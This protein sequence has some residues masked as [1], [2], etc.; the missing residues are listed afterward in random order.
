MPNHSNFV[1]LLRDRAQEMPEQTLYSFLPDGETVGSSLT[2]GELDQRARAIAATLQQLGVQGERA[3]LIYPWGASLEFIAAF[4]GCLYAGVVAVTTY[5][6]RPNQSLGGFQ[7]RLTSSQA[8]LVLTTSDQLNKLDNQQL[9]DLPLLLSTQKL[10]TDTIPTKES[11]SWIESTFSPDTLAF[12]QYTSGSTG[13]PKGVMVTHGNLIHNSAAIHASFQTSPQD[14]SLI[15]LPLFHDMGLIGGVLQPLYAGFRVTLMS[16]VTFLQNPLLWL[17][18]ISRYR[19]TITGAPNFAYDQCA[20]K[21]P[22]SVLPS[23]DLSS[24][25]VAFSGAEPVRAE[26][27][28]LFASK[29]APCGFRKEA[30]Y[31]CYGMAEAT[32]LVSGGLRTEIPQVQYVEGAALEENRVVPAVPGAQGTRS[33]VSCGRTWEGQKVVIVHPETRIPVNTG[34]VGEIWVSGEGL[35]KGYWQQPEETEK[36]FHAYLAADAH[37]LPNGPYLR[38]GDLGFLLDEDLFITGRLKNT[39]VIWGRN[40]YPQNIEHTAENSHPALRPSCS[41]AFAVEIDGEERLVVALEVER[42]HLRQLDA[43]AVVEC[44][45]QALKKEYDLEVSAVL[46][47]KTATIPKTSSGK[48]QRLACRD[49][50]LEGSLDLVAQWSNFQ[51]EQTGVLENWNAPEVAAAP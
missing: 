14:H 19:A 37:N 26:T 29:F 21:I 22:E 44:V 5:P 51:V 39:I 10:A 36:T 42:T 45:R 8:N 16:P 31:P 11:A 43:D 48:I 6:P 33:V 46:L 23:L 15:W 7:A 40:H 18:A 1:N 27:L 50:F 2:Y 41:A 25:Q 35:G 30:F 49:K 3:L 47:L 34:Q 13:T 38:T 17:K 20:R 28:D 9:Q 24:L 4:F 32:L 12:L